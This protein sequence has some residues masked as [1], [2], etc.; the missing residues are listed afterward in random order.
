M[1]NVPWTG[2]PAGDNNSG[3][4]F[5]PDDFVS[6]EQYTEDQL[7]LNTRIINIGSVAEYASDQTR[8][9]AQTITEIR[10]LISD[11]ENDVEENKEDIS[12]IMPKV[13][14]LMSSVQNLTNGLAEIN[15]EISAINPKLSVMSEQIETL[16]TGFAGHEEDI[17][18]LL[19][20]TAANIQSITS[21]NSS[22]NQLRE[23]LL[24]L[25]NA[26]QEQSARV[27]ANGVKISNAET[28]IENIEAQITNITVVISGLNERITALET[29]LADYQSSMLGKTDQIENRLSEYASDLRNAESEIRTNQNIIAQNTA[30]INRINASLSEMSTR[31][32]NDVNVLTNAVTDTN[33]RIDVTNSTLADLRRNHAE[34]VASLTQRIG[35]ANTTAVSAK[36]TADNAM[37]AVNA[38]QS[39]VRNAISQMNTRIDEIEQA[40]P[41]NILRFIAKPNICEIGGIE[42]I[43][44]VWDVTGDIRKIMLN[45]IDVTDSEGTYT[46][47]GLQTNS[48]YTLKV[49]TKG[50]GTMSKTIGV[51]FVNHIYWGV[52]AI[53]DMSKAIV[54]GLANTEMTDETEREIVLTLNNEHAVYAYPKRLG[55]VEFEVSGF[56]GGFEMPAEISIDNHADYSE[57]YYV[58]RSTQKL[59]GTAL[60][61]IKKP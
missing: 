60:F 26:L 46:V 31:H 28:A 54:K 37:N 48:E 55:L 59:S 22:L 34:D 23:T 39:E 8:T 7:T 51:S 6:K 25:T 4:E 3:T 19:S 10:G 61:K 9:I 47:P 33:S 20:T 2:L 5:N 16:T 56:K 12:D 30:D 17:E 40:E 15:S 41:A 42:N 11:V 27:S 32:Q 38:Y 14:A 53:S 49:I 43:V 50:G 52:S 1:R 57:D 21:L 58:Y 36:G 35:N 44:F 13:S 45:D 29:R 18:Q 24:T